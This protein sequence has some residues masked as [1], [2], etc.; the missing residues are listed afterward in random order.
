MLNEDGVTIYNS[1]GL[2]EAPPDEWDAV[3]G[4]NIAKQYGLTP[5]TMQDY[6]F[7]EGDSASRPLSIPGV[8]AER[9]QETKDPDAYRGGA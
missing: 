7:A 8:V 5:G 6:T 9:A 2:S 4:D 3:N 1:T